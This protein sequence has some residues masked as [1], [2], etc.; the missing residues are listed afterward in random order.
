MPKRKSFSSEFKRE[1]VRLLRDFTEAS[2]R[3]YLSAS[4]P[5]TGM[6]SDS[7]PVCGTPGPRSQKGIRK[8]MNSN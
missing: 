8:A 1:A 2:G 4:R 6:K 7:T 5:P 3:R